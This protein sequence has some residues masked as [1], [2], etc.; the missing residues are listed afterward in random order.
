MVDKIEV[1]SENKT[2]T[3]YKIILHRAHTSR[4]LTYVAGADSVE[5]AKDHYHSLKGHTILSIS[6]I[7]KDGSSRDADEWKARERHLF[8]KNI[9]GSYYAPTGEELQAIEEMLAVHRDDGRKKILAAIKNY[10]KNHKS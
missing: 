9:C 2:F 5:S 8:I 1:L 10:K 3:W 6:E 7:D 4:Y